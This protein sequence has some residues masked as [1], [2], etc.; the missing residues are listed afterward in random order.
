MGINRTSKSLSDVQI[1]EAV[2]EVIKGAESEA[3]AA[4]APARF[5]SAYVVIEKDIY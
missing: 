5:V 1:V 2:K 3:R 4:G